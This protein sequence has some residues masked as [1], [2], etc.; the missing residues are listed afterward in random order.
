MQN[1]INAEFLRIE[2]ESPKIFGGVQLRSMPSTT[3]R[4]ILNMTRKAVAQTESNVKLE[5]IKSSVDRFT[6][7]KYFNKLTT[8]IAQVVNNYL[9]GIKQNDTGSIVADY[10]ELCMYLKTVINWKT[11][12]ETDR[13]TITAKFNELIPQVNELMDVAI[14]EKYT[15]VKQIEELRNNLMVRN[16]APIL[17]LNF[18]DAIKS[19]KPDYKTRK[20]LSTKLFALLNEPLLDD[21]IKTDLEDKLEVYDDTRNKYVSAK[22]AD[23]KKF[24][25]GIL[26][27]QETELNGYIS[28]IFESI[29]KIPERGMY[30]A[31]LDISNLEPLPFV[32]PLRK[33][34]GLNKEEL[35][36]ARRE[37]IARKLAERKQKRDEQLSYIYKPYDV[38][39]ESSGLSEK[40][41]RQ[42]E[43]FSER[44]TDEALA[45][46]E[47]YADIR[48]IKENTAKDIKQ[49]TD[50]YDDDIRRM[51]QDSVK[52]L[53]KLKAMNDKNVKALRLASQK[54]QAD[55]NMFEA[56]E[57]RIA[58]YKRNKISQK[59]S[60]TKDP[61]KV[62]E[63]TILKRQ[64]DED[65]KHVKEIKIDKLRFSIKQNEDNINQL[66]KNYEDRRID[67]I[68]AF[69]FRKSDMTNV[70]DESVDDLKRGAKLDIKQR[71]RLLPENEMLITTQQRKPKAF[72]NVKERQRE[73]LQWQEERKPEI[74]QRKRDIAAS[75]EYYREK[76]IRDRKYKADDVRERKL[77]QKNMD[78]KLMA[79][80]ER[81]MEDEYKRMSGTGRTQGAGRRGRP[82]KFKGG[83]HAVSAS[84]QHA[85]SASGEIVEKRLRNAV[86]KPFIPKNSNENDPDVDL[87]PTYDLSQFDIKIKRK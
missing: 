18:A 34:D 75:N 54:L 87:Y 70:Y 67:I 64:N 9:Q 15:D 26:D 22:N 50:Q 56:M 81:A 19:K 3:A 49:L 58:E 42:I 31:E 21:A 78:D 63:Y 41:S 48:D 32:Q 11:L 69:D 12:S 68:R 85:V 5:D 76:Q 24:Y 29:P 6:V 14:T 27:K 65:K 25:K 30:E 55:V 80:E 84:G 47:T 46:M 36:I 28:G 57:K 73:R 1:H 16:Y 72:A 83:Q 77:Q 79:E 66:N 44:K 86:R 38:R 33:L 35:K 51:E 43:Q 17:Y 39:K 62:D 20:E 61:T 4:D 59:L 40:D 53:K 8:S 60:V 2:N 71:E 10:N 7:D 37:E 82:R 74:E 52:Q 13:N 45:P 23:R